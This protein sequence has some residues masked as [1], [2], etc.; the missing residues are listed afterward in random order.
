MIRQPDRYQHKK[1]L[2]Y[3][4]GDTVEYVDQEA[5]GDMVECA[6]HDEIY[7]NI[8]PD[9]LAEVATDELVRDLIRCGVRFP[10]E[11]T[12]LAMFV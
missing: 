9:E 11:G 2:G 8:M 4:T 7:L 12:G 10:D 6:E 1:R 3:T 5:F